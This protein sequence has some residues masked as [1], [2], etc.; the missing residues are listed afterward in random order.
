MDEP[1]ESFQDRGMT[2][3]GGRQ[4]RQQATSSRRTASAVDGAQVKSL[5]LVDLELDGGILKLWQREVGAEKTKQC[6][7]RMALVLSRLTN[8]KVTAGE[9]RDFRYSRGWKMS[10]AQQVERYGWGP[11]DRPVS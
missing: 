5:L 2:L 4:F 11:N 7:E 8:R 10:R 6:D 3:G 1:S 9:W